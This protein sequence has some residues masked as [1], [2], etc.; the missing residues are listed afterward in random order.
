VSVSLRN[1]RAALYAYSDAGANGLVSP[2]YTKTPSAASD[3]NWWASRGVPT[4]REA[5]VA[6]QAALVADSVWGFDAGA[7]V[8]APGLIVDV[9]TGTAFKITAILPRDLSRSEVQVLA[10][11]STDAKYT[12]TP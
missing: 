7:P 9:L 11:T 4:G 8:T 12:E 6:Q 3:G 1:R 2:A 10:V 5:L